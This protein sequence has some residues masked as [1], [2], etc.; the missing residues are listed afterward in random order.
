MDDWLKQYQ[1][2]TPKLLPPTVFEKINT[3]SN[4]DDNKNCETTH[5]ISSTLTSS[6]SLQANANNNNTTLTVSNK[7]QHRRLLNAS[8]R[9]ANDFYYIGDA[10]NGLGN[11]QHFI[12]LS[13]E[14]EKLKNEIRKLHGE[15][16]TLRHRNRGKK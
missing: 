1:S 8:T 6:N 16:E 15:N 2:S 3:S 14:L 11:G 7:N 9:S 13:N 4:N 10:G 5:N 12:M